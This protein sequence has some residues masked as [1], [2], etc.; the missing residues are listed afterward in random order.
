MN[1]GQDSVTLAYRAYM[2]HVGHN[3]AS[4]QCDQ[5]VAN[6]SEPTQGC[7]EGQRLWGLYRLSRIA[8]P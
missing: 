1:L 2:R 6:R 3:K 8:G 5:C 7:A 4:E